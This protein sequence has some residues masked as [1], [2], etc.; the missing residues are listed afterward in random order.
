MIPNHSMDPTDDSAQEEAG[1]QERKAKARLAD[2]DLPSPEA[3]QA[4]EDDDPNP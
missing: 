2:P 1:R 4:A 3:G